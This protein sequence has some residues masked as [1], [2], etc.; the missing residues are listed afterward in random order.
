MIKNN[1]RTNP[2]LSL[3][4]RTSLEKGG[5]FGFTLIE[6]LIAITIGML[7]IGLGSV[8]LNNFNENQKL[9]STRKEL[10][11]NLRLA[12][13]YAVTNQLKEG[14]DRSSVKIN[15]DGTVTIITQTDANVDIDPAF[16]SKDITPK[17]IWIKLDND[18]RFSVTDGR[19]I[20]GI[21]NVGVSGNNSVK[22]I[23]IDESGL[24]Y[25]E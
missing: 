2:P 13:N 22:N 19:S 21:V 3:R 8:T 4:S 9:E 20:N 5:I 23:K 11:S 17:N 25:E 14:G 16:F 15:L 6:L 10:I 1:Q 7:M 24:I 12:R 18:I